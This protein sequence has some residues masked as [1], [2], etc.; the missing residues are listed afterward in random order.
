MACAFRKRAQKQLQ[1]ILAQHWE[2]KYKQWFAENGLPNVKNA[3]E[4][5]VIMLGALDVV[6]QNQ[7]K[8]ARSVQ[9]FIDD[10]TPDIQSREDEQ[11]E[12]DAKLFKR[13]SRTPPTIFREKKL[14]DWFSKNRDVY[15][16][17]IAAIQQLSVDDPQYETANEV[18]RSEDVTKDCVSLI[19]AICH[20]EQS[21]SKLK[22]A[23][24]RFKSDFRE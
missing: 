7:M 18:C 5:S 21:D 6:C 11:R 17:I 8:D 15:A 10:A 13:W 12:Y 19:D 20:G 1:G 14:L 2:T 9:K 4:A 16:E 3:L 24:G 23:C 22:N